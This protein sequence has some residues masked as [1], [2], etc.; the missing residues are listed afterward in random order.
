MTE[1]QKQPEQQA[2]GAAHAGSI[3]E[4]RTFLFGKNE[5][6]NKLIPPY[7]MEGVRDVYTQ[8]SLANFMNRSS[9][10]NEHSSVEP[11]EKKD[12]RPRNFNS[13]E[14]VIGIAATK[15][16]RDVSANCIISIEK[17]DKAPEDFSLIEVKAVIFKKV[18]K[19]TYSKTEYHSKM[20]KQMSGST[21]PVKEL[22]MEAVN[23]GYISKDDRI[24]CVV[25]ESVGSGYKGLLMI[26]DVDKIFFNIST[27]HLTENINAEVLESVL[28]IALEI[29]REGREGRKIGTAFIIGRKSELAKHTK[30]LIINPFASVPD[31]MKKIVDPN[32]KETVK[33]FA[34]L[35]GVFLIGE[36]GTILSAGAYL[37]LDLGA[38]ELHGL[39]GFGTRHRHSAAITQITDAVAVVVSES[40]GVVR[41]FKDGKPVMKLP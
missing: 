38:L 2:N 29:S 32:I 4:E 19:N 37:S 36:E 23:N 21:I 17:S 16:A 15:I 31:E 8:Q 30:Q 27:H 14:E 22:L 33:G 35:D 39:E 5:E 13:V 20:K 7:L 26:F 3:G 11:E 1:A 25:D 18:K 28:N 6:R 41:V 10:L 34:Q 12:T 40:G 24:V 9:I